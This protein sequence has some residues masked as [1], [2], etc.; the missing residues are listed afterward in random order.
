MNFGIKKQFVVV[1]KYPFLLDITDM[2]FVIVILSEKQNQLFLNDV[3]SASIIGD[4]ILCWCK[5][6]TMRHSN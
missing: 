3:K 1:G 4:I 5:M 6:I 2:K